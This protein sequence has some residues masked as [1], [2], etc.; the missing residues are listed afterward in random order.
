MSDSMSILSL[1]K[2]DHHEIE[3]LIDSLT[4]SLNGSYDVMRHH[5]ERFEWKLEK[6]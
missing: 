2:Q 6:T 3:A 4:D 5:F 1:M